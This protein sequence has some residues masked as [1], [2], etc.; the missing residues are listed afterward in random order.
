MQQLSHPGDL[1]SNS[2]DNF[3]RNIRGYAGFGVWYALLAVVQWG[4]IVV[5]RAMFADVFARNIALSLVSVPVALCATTLFIAMVHATT[6]G[7]Q[8]KPVMPHV[9]LTI[10]LHRLIPFLWVMFLTLGVYVLGMLLF[11][12]PFAIFTNPLL[13]FLCLVPLFLLGVRLWFAPF[14]VIVDDI[15][16][17]AALTE[18]RASTL[19]R[20]WDV[21][22]RLLFPSIFYSVCATFVSRLIFLVLGGLLGDPGTF[23]DHFLITDDISNTQL[24]LVTVVPSLI[25]ALALPLLYGSWALLWLDLKKARA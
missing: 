17:V 16:G 5:C 10:A 15:R 7:V 25:N 3:I 22:I 2:W 19:G 6:Q 11:A 13:L 8:N 23:N 24:L 9:S 4:L 21:A 1:I 18:S 12:I 14:N 20:W